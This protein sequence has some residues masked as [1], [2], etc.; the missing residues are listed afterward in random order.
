MKISRMVFELQSRHNFVTD[1]QTYGRTEDQGKN[2]MS[3]NPTGGDIKMFA[4]FSMSISILSGV[5]R[6]I[7]QN[8][9]PPFLNI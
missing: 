2:N 5:E 4:C 1:R 6:K 8:S 3:P 9:I 7:I